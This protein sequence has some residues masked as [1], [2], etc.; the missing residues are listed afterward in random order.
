MIANSSKTVYHTGGIEATLL[1]DLS[2]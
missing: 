2:R 1:G